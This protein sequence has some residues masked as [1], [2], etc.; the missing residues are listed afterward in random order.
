MGGRKERQSWAECQLMH[1]GWHTLQI[2]SLG[3]SQWDI[4]LIIQQ[5]HD[6]ADKVSGT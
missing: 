4:R 3:K 5:S 6:R 1:K 2:Q